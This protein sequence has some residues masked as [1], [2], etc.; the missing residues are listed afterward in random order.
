M[1]D[2]NSIMP[3]NTI[4]DVRTTVGSAADVRPPAQIPRANWNWMDETASDA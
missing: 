2:K 4:N 1:I 3:Y